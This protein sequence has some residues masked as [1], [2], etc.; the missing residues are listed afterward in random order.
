MLPLLPADIHILI[1]T[2]Y[3]QH[4]STAHGQLF[5]SLQWNF[6]KDPSQ[7]LPVPTCQEQWEAG[8]PLSPAGSCAVHMR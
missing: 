7:M 3:P 2:G 8:S 4:F 5:Q 6:S 1:D